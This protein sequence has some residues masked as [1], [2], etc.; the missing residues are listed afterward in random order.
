M[1]YLVGKQMAVQQQIVEKQQLV[2]VFPSFAA[3][4]Q[5]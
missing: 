4:G 5:D 2:E 3:L 1:N